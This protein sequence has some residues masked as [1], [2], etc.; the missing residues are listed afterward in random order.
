MTLKSNPNNLVKYEKSVLL[1]SNTA[2]L[3][4]PGLTAE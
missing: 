3:V 4:G 2:R 1:N